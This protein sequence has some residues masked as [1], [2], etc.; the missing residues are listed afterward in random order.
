VSGRSIVRGGVE[1]R[2]SGSRS[3]DDHIL[4]MLETMPYSERS[5]TAVVTG[6]RALRDRARAAETV[7][8]GPDWLAHR[9]ADPSRPSPR[10]GVTPVGIGR[11]RPPRAATA[12][13]AGT[14]AADA[15][16]SDADVERWRPGRGSTRKRG[17]PRRPPRTARSG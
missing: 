16:E 6:D 3:A 5:R 11:P 13:A 14:Q 2:H 15:A 4:W 12:A 9:L 8:H 17:N 7:C 10:P 1:V